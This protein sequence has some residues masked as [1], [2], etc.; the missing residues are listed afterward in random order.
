MQRMLKIFPLAALFLLALSLPVLAAEAPQ[1]PILTVNGTGQATAAP[2]QATAVIGIT[3][4]AGDAAKAQ[5]DNAWTANQIHKAIQALGVKAKDIQTTDYSFQPTYREEQNHRNEINGYTVNNSIVVT[6]RDLKLT[7]KVID[8][9]LSHGANEVSSL[10]FGASDS[11]AVQQAALKAACLDARAKADIIAQALGKH[12][13]GIQNVSEST[14]GLSGRRYNGPMLAMAKMDEAT[15]IA[16]GTL[17]LNANVHIDF[18]L[19]NE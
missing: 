13:V 12:I 18:I 5:N 10:S 17:T 16:A 15:P 14:S 6:I 9:A 3:T 19:S 7:G 11:H 8:A 2:D 1:K 4:H